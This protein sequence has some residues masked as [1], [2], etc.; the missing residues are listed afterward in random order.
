MIVAAPEGLKHTSNT[1]SNE[2]P[3]VPKHSTGIV[4]ETAEKRYPDTDRV[5]LSTMS[6]SNDPMFRFKQRRRLLREKKQELLN[7]QPKDSVRNS[8]NNLTHHSFVSPRNRFPEKSPKKLSR[9][10]SNPY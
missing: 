3:D 4:T 6:S 9:S 7:R 8:L 1:K 2:S 5:K 10:M